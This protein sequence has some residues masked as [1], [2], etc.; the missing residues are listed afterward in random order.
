M[1]ML[2]IA[3]AVITLLLNGTMNRDGPFQKMTM[4][5]LTFTGKCT[6]A[7]ISPDGKYVAYV[8]K[9]SE[10]QSL[11]L[12]QVAVTSNIE[13][14][15]T[16]VAKYQGITFSPDSS[17][18]FFVVYEGNNSEAALY[19]VPVLGGTPRQILSDVDT[20]I[21]FS[22]DGGKFAFVRTSPRLEEHA[23]MIA[24][25]DGT[26]ERKLARRK[27]PDG[28]LWP[29]WSP[30]GSRIACA[31]WHSDAGG[32]YGNVVEI[33]TDD[34]IEELITAHKWSRVERM[35]WLA[36]GSGLIIIATEPSSLQQLW[37]I[38]YPSGETRRITNDLDNYHSVSL[39]AD[40]NTIATVQSR[41]LW[42]IW[43]VP[44]SD[45]SRAKQ[46][47][48]GAGRKDGAAN[49]ISWTPDGKIVF[50][51]NI[52]G[53]QDLWMMEADGSNQKQ[54]TFD[55]GADR[56][57]SV[58][59]DGRY[60]VFASDDRF[61]SNIWRMDIDGS[62]LKRLTGGTR[63]IDPRISRDG[64]WVVYQSR[65]SAGRRL[66]KVGIEGNNSEQLSNESLSRPAIS[67]DGKWIAC[68][69]LGP[70]T[71]QHWKIAVIPSEGDQP[72]KII[73]TP[74]VI[75]QSVRVSWDRD[76]RALLYIVTLADVSNIWSQSLDGGLPKLLTHFKSE[77]ISAF[78]L[79]PDSK[80]LACSRGT[81]NGDVVLISNPR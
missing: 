34:G 9:E 79:S 22:P 53:N 11:L 1:A 25:A 63:D 6:Y 59:S 42:H 3:M 29:A 48:F 55:S 78:D 52:S 36:K 30:D 49:G 58:S 62:N 2:L 26:E 32:I 65:P 75:D 73:D 23:L 50:E 69:Y 40:S 47:T 20:P 46:I 66:W 10:G 60:V 8:I 67:P 70:Q 41:S 39:T 80:Q 64:T 14:I 31:A 74:S 51:S 57:P 13:I 16:R 43:I 61:A 72:P 44:V 38:S 56:T 19:K 5:R 27:D 68:L 33:S 7:A 21:T 4:E 17:H 15:P 37:H 45:T 12:K 77:L 28:F 71:G 24:N 76:G 54:L 18:I 81:V 35:V